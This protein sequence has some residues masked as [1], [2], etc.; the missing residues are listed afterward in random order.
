MYSEVQSC[1]QVNQK[2]TDFFDI[3]TGLRQGCILSPLLFNLFIND[4]AV[5]IK[6]LNLGV[7]AAG[8]E[9]ISLLMYA[10]DIVLIADNAHDLQCMIDEVYEFSRKNRFEL[11]LEKDKTHV[12]VFGERATKESW[13]FGERTIIETRQYKYLGVTF[14]GTLNWQK[15]HSKALKE[16]NRRAMGLLSLGQV[17]RIPTTK[18]IEVYVTRILTKLH[19]GA[20]IWGE[21]D[22]EAAERMQ[23]KLAKRILRFRKTVNDDAVRG[24]LGFVK[25]KRNRDYQR[26]V[27]WGYL[28]SMDIERL[29]KRIYVAERRLYEERLF[30]KK[31][32]RT[33]P[34]TE[35][36]T[37]K[38]R[39][40]PNPSLWLEETVKLIKEFQLEDAWEA[41][42][43]GNIED[44]KRRVHEAV[45]EKEEEE[46]KMRMQN[47]ARLT[48]LYT[49][50]KTELK[51]ETYLLDESLSWEA[52]NILFQLRTGSNRL[53]IDTG[54]WEHIPRDK[55]ICQL[56]Q[57]AVENETHFMFR[58]PVLQEERQKMM[59]SVRKKKKIDWSHKFVTEKARTAAFVGIG[60]EDHAQR[61][62]VAAGLVRMMR[63]REQM[64]SNK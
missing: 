19:Y 51:C 53:R 59:E 55:R 61:K 23:I 20:E 54:R 33:E 27:Y 22:W 18:L 42:S 64:L 47:Q 3:D 62:L 39:P 5:K 16:V 44:W 58:C 13:K 28:V 24:E 26:L 17:A 46:W 35:K 10:D 21:G 63:T 50:I 30:A 49:T 34:S 40:K 38:P 14:G 52:R 25:L 32:E 7:Q 29:P 57:S 1:V 36:P 2:K 60:L 41:Q 9:K 56:C 48:L 43:V 8:K 4:L 31:E 37:N 6:E 11:N 15:Q 45:H 12:V